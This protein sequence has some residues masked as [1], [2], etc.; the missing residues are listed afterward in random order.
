MTKTEALQTVY[1][2]ADI[3]LSGWGEDQRSI[4]DKQARK[5]GEAMK[6]I[7]KQLGRLKTVRAFVILDASHVELTVPIDTSPEK[8]KE[9]ILEQADNESHSWDPEIQI[10][11]D[12]SPFPPLTETTIKELIQ[13]DLLHLLNSHPELAVKACQIVIDRFK[14]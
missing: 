4:E 8:V 14:G 13:A 1:V 12:L 11:S 7:G 5:Y 3:L 9:L 6:I 10:E 2:L